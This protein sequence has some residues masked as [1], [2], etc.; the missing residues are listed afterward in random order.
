L[1][2]FEQYV[3]QG[4]ISSVKN[5]FPPNFRFKPVKNSKNQNADFMGWYEEF[6]FTAA[7]CYL[8]RASYQSS[9]VIIII[10]SGFGI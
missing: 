6:P 9:V 4:W 8:K 1:A 10:I 5:P 3:K 2:F 7:V